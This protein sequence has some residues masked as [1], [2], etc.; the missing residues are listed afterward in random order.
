MGNDPDNNKLHF[1]AAIFP[2]AM[3]ALVATILWQI[4]HAFK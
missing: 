2:P 4:E 3:V 1:A